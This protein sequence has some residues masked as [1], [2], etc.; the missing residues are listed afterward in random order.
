M[1]LF[2]ESGSGKSTLAAE[3]AAELE[4]AG[5]T[6]LCIG[7]DPGSPAFGMPGAICLGQWGNGA[8][9]LLAME[10]LCSLDAGRFRLPLLD[11]VRRLADSRAGGTLFIDS[12]GVVRG[13]SGAEL[14]T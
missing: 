13:V 1:L 9:Q 5:S 2:G 11:G 7:A 4:R 10:A 12:P 14:L 3:L 6:C 8:W